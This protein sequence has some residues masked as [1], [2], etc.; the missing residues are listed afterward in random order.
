MTFEQLLVFHTIVRTGSFK[1]A[2]NEMHK[3]QPA[4]SFSIKKLE[5]ELQVELFDRSAYRPTL[6]DHGRAL[7]ERSLKIMQGMAEL[8]SMSKSFQQKEEPEISISLDGVCLKPDVLKLLKSFSDDHPYTKLNLSFD[9]L[10]E[11]ERKVTSKEALFGI[12]HFVSEKSH[13]ELVPVTKV[14]MVPVINR[15]LYKEKK[16]KSQ[17]DLLGIDQIVVGDKNPTGASF[18]LLEEGKKWRM[19]DINFKHDIILAGL[20]WGHLPIH[21]VER[22]IKDKKI[23]VLNFEDIHP[24]DLEIYLI[25]LKKH[26]FGP[27]AKM[28]WEEL[29]SFHL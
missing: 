10:S 2:S 27:V 6:T 8:E 14:T 29:I 13:L 3:T 4:I 24:R 12:T 7:Y 11:A 23:I 25:R 28:L 1:A 26:Q 16:V 20:G 19:L 17:K 21:A 5:E 22:E 18:G 15:E 9:I